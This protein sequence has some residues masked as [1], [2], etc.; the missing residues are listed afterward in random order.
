MII[1]CIQSLNDIQLFPPNY[2]AITNSNFCV[3]TFDSL[4]ITVYFLEVLTRVPSVV[5]DITV[6]H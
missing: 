5:N 3:V 6:V 4:K 1:F 2:E